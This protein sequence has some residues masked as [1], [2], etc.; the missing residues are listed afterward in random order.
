M[1][2]VA[3]ELLNDLIMGTQRICSFF[4]AMN[5]K[6]AGV[7]VYGVAQCAETITASGCLDCL[8]VA[9]TNIK[10]CS[11]KHAEGRAFDGACFIRFSNRDFFPDNQ[12]TDI[13]SSL[14]EGGRTWSSL[15]PNLTIINS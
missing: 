15:F 8:T 3:L 12:I 10:G 11:P 2:L 6:E 13:R 9:Y 5:K 4:A 1:N 7:T 14:G